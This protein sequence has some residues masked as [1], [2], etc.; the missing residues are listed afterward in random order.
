[1][2]LRWHWKVLFLRPWVRI[3]ANQQPQDTVSDIV[4]AGCD[5]PC[6]LLEMSSFRTFICSFA[7]HVTHS[8][9]SCHDGRCRTNA[10]SPCLTLSKRTQAAHGSNS[11][12]KVASHSWIHHGL[13][14]AAGQHV[15]RPVRTVQDL[16]NGHHLAKRDTIF[17]H[18]QAPWSTLKAL[19][20]PTS[21]SHQS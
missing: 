2:H 1:M 11:L 14:A 19:S 21:K 8:R 15:W 13:Q 18:V 12:F 5:L 17:G 4:N 10:C 20:L 16:E 9:A 6:A 7:A 3:G